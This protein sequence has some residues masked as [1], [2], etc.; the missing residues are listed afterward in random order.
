[1]PH[2]GLGGH[3][4]GHLFSV[5]SIAVVL[6]CQALWTLTGQTV[7]S[8]RSCVSIL[9]NRSQRE[10][11]CLSCY[12]LDKYLAHQQLGQKKHF[13]QLPACAPSRKSGHGG[14]LLT[15][16]LLT[17]AFLQHPGL[18]A[19]I[20]WALPHQ[21]IIKTMP[22]HLTY[23]P[24]LWVHFSQLKLPFPGAYDRKLPSTLVTCE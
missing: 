1:V 8:E 19:H 6:A 4:N 23:R 13:F 9:I 10:P 2:P 16:L 3:V 24:I 7:F 18:P 11:C 5:G 22:H 20:G 12:S 21:L 14:V 17:A 15:G